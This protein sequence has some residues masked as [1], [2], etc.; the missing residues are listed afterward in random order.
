MHDIEM[1][2]DGN[3]A[4]FKLLLHQS[5][6]KDLYGQRLFLLNT[7]ASGTEVVRELA[8]GTFNTKTICE[9]FGL[10]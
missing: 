10:L 6:G 7:S 5:K 9:I 1:A 3:L 8:S 4:H 2:L